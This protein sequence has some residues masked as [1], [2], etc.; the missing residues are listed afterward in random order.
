MPLSW[1]LSALSS[2]GSSSSAWEPRINAKEASKLIG[3][4]GHYS[5]RELYG[6]TFMV[7]VLDVREAFGRTDVEV[8][9]I[10]GTGTHWVSLG[11]VRLLK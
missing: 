6:L 7:E 4:R 10:A 5:H 1:P 11:N 2:Y 3:K 8:R 9:P